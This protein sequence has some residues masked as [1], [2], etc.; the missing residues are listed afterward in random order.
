MTA[1]LKRIESAT[2]LV[3]QRCVQ[4]AP[5][6]EHDDDLTSEV[7]ENATEEIDSFPDTADELQEDASD[8]DEDESELSVPAS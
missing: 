4:E 8:T 3:D 5:M 2:K 1:P 7:R 6:D